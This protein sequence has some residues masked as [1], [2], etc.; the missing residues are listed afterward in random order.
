MCLSD[1]ACIQQGHLGGGLSGPCIIMTVKAA[2]ATTKVEASSVRRRT[3]RRGRRCWRRTRGPPNIA[4][5]DVESVTAG[6]EH[7]RRGRSALPGDT[8]WSERG[9]IEARGRPSS[10]GLGCG[11]TPAQSDAS[12]AGAQGGGTRPLLLPTLQWRLDYGPRSRRQAGAPPTLPSFL[13]GQLRRGR[14]EL[15]SAAAQNR[16]RPGVGVAPPS[17]SSYPP[18]GRRNAGSPPSASLPHR[19]GDR[20]PDQRSTEDGCPHLPTLPNTEEALP[21]MAEAPRRTEARGLSR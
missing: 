16:R 6:G 8:E 15:A 17:A 1:R 7:L 5:A 21:G 13:V 2:V 14:T 19:T 20:R 12:P 10:R 4:G 3:T 11:D 18:S 9:E